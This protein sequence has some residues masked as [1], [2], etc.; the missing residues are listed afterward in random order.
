V[1]GL[2]VVTGD[3]RVLEFGGRVVK[4]VAGYD[5]VRLIVGSR[6]R[7]G[8]ITRV[9][10]RLKPAPAVDETIAVGCGS[11]EQAVDLVDAMQQLD[12]VALEIA[13]W[14]E[15]TLLA[16]F[17][18]NREAVAA[19][20]ATVAS[21]APASRRFSGGAEW[22]AFNRVEA[23]SAVRVRFANLPSGL[24][25]TF[26]VAS[27]F[28]SDAG[29]ADARFAAHAGSGIV[30]VLADHDTAGALAAAREQGERLTAQGGS[31]IMERLAGAAPDQPRDAT[32]RKL[33][34]QI[35][36]VFDPAGVLG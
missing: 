4:N 14:P 29:L 16:R 33:M 10:L 30:R 6:G 12:P 21:L 22:R 23:G 31:V 20:I 34:D 18:G 36:T 24:R 11:F 3:G 19:G 1:L 8:F 28:A 17:H 9:N 35:R 32:I 15:W 2:E 25:E 27:D 26:A 13:S 5:V 7:L